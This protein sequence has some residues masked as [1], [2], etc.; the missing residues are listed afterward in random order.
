[1]ARKTINLVLSEY[2]VKDIIERIGNLEDNIKV[3]CEE[4]ITE[5]L[6]EGLKMAIE[7][8]TYAPKT[9]NDD[10]S[11]KSEYLGRNKGYI[12]MTGSDS[13]YVEFGTGDVGQNESHPL[14]NKVAGINP[15]NSGPTIRLDDIGRHYWVYPPLANTGDYYFE[16]GLT[17]GIPAGCQM[18]NTLLDLK[19]I[20]PNIANKHLNKA[21]RSRL[22]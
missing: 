15:Y 21:I 12:A 6:E 5:L 14:H 16:G 2:G 18:Y 13:V 17:Y 20:A 9:G 4:M 8:D 7:N 11:F 10:Y 3:S 22:V 19:K 1:M